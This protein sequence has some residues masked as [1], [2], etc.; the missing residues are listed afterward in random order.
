ML[1]FIAHIQEKK[2]DALA[3]RDFKLF[4]P[5]YEVAFGRV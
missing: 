3:K 4:K 1:V 2:R 5:G